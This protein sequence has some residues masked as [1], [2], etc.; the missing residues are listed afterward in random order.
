MKTYLPI[1]LSYV[2]KNPKSFIFSFL[3][4]NFPILLFEKAQGKPIYMDYIE[5]FKSF[6]I[7]FFILL[8]QTVLNIQFSNCNQW[9]QSTNKLFEDFKKRDYGILIYHYEIKSIKNVEKI[10][11]ETL[12]F[13]NLLDV[14]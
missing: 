11:K 10:K 1:F 14:T 3:R 5:S 2:T 12:P 4:A 6:R 13:L 8:D 7:D 9:K